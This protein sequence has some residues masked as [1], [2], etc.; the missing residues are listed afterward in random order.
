MRIREKNPKQHKY[1]SNQQTRMRNLRIK[2]KHKEKNPQKPTCNIH[3]VNTN[4]YRPNVWIQYTL[5]TYRS[6]LVLCIQ[7]SHI[8]YQYTA[9]F[10]TDISKSGRRNAPGSVNLL[11]N[12]GTQ[13]PRQQHAHG[14]SCSHPQT[15]AGGKRLKG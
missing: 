15:P 8:L 13:Q 2:I 4:I 12:C 14:C 7:D 5:N 11:D 6:K 1:H 3:P 9:K 10:Y